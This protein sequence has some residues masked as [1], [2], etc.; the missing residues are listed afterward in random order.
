MPYENQYGSKTAHSDVVQNPDV[1]AFLQQCLPL[2][3]PSDAEAQSFADLFEPVPDESDAEAP[4]NFVLA[5]DGSPYVSSID[6]RIPSIQVCYLKFST[7][8]LEMF[9][10]EGLEDQAT[11]FIDPFRVAALQRN[12]DT[13][14]VVLPLSNFK[15]PEDAS[16]RQSFRRQID[17]FLRS[18]S[19]RFR[20]EDENTSLMGTLVEL[21]QL[22]HLP[23]TTPGTV[24]IQRCPNPDCDQN[25]IDLDP[26]Q[27]PFHCPGCGQE[28]FVSDCLRVWEAVNDYHP[29]Q[30]GASRFMNYV[31]HLLAIHYLRF[32]RDTSPPL[33]SELAVFVDGPLAV[34][35]QAAWLHAA[36]M[37][38][39]HRLREVQWTRDLLPPVVIGLQKTGYVVEYM[40]LLRDHVA[41]NRVYAI[42]DSFR[43]EQLGVQP[44]RNGFGSETYYGQDFVLKSAGGKLFV[45]SLPYPFSSKAVVS[46]FPEAKARIGNY[47]ELG[48]AIALMNRGETDLYRDALIPVALAH[49]FTAISL[50]PGGHVLDVMG[51]TTRNH[52]NSNKGA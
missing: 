1:Q 17:R 33:L 34:F 38:F 5:S 12:R 43:H 47:P 15:L 32:L 49:R 10:M 48:R 42:T 40:Q 29:N 19:T 8:L 41:A 31:E 18:P 39:L 35:G 44:S 21:A 25:A 52:G 16:V 46:D 27:S 23:D 2:R 13:L 6:K 24:R 50:K 11:R 45:F 4:I 26:E 7:I 51:R 22:R 36:I 9:K 20:T 14:S 37:R 28:L 3:E 30:E